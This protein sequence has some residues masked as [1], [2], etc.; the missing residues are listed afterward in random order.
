MSYD[1]AKEEIRKELQCKI[2]ALN[3]L[4]NYKYVVVCTFYQGNIVLSKHKFRETWE[5]QGGHIE[6]GECPIDA[7]KRELFEESGIT[8]A[9]IHPVCDYYG[10]NSKNHSNGMVF[11]AIAH[12]LNELPE[13]EMNSIELFEKLPDNLTYPQVTPILFEEAGKVV[14]KL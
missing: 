8:D 9:D 14:L 3:S 7:A 2:Y 13:F 5:T 6:E 1:K 12:T 4:K 10:Y 11:M